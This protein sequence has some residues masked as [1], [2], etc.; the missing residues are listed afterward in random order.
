[1]PRS[2][3]REAAKLHGLSEEQ[4]SRLIEQLPR[5]V[6]AAEWWVENGEA[7]PTPEGVPLEPGRWARIIAA[8]RALVGRPPPPSPAPGGS[9]LTPGPLEEHVPLQVAPR[10]DVMT[11]LDKDG[12]ERIGLVKIDLLGNRALGTLE[13]AERLAAH[14][15]ALHGSANTDR[16]GSDKNP[17][18]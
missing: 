6:E 2:A 16:H 3:F 13:E 14:G 15:A 11:Q 18:S 10:G 12:V 8:A 9:V 17:F 1:Q 5:G 4:T 7:P